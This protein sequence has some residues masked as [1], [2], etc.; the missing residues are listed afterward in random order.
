MCTSVCRSIGLSVGCR[1]VGLSVG[2]SVLS[3]VCPSACA[4]FVPPWTFCFWPCALALCFQ[5]SPLQPALAYEM[6]NCLYSRHMQA[7]PLFRELPE[8]VIT[9]LCF[10]LMPY[11]VSKGEQV[12]TTGD[13]RPQS[14]A[15]L[16]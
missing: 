13:V 1:F 16:C 11:P 7:V 15:V 2:P 3:L 4:S 9:E 10:M 12:Y 14:F 5:L 6:V 8:E